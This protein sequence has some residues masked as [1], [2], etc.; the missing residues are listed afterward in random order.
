MRYFNQTGKLSPKYKSRSY[1]ACAC[2][3]VRPCVR[4]F[5]C[6]PVYVPLC[7][8]LCP[9]FVATYRA[10]RQVETR[11]ISPVVITIQVSHYFVCAPEMSSIYFV[12]ACS[13]DANEGTCN[14]V[15]YTC[16]KLTI[17]ESPS[18]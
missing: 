12:S 18:I 3:C 10:R 9:S 16:E 17:M 11:L 1:R 15:N 5:V 13:Y 7:G 2:L 4:A 6:G 14:V 8:A